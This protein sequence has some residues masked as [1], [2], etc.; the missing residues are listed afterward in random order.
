AMQEVRNQ[1]IAYIFQQSANVFNPSMK[2]GDQ[3]AE[4]ALYGKRTA[5]PIIR[6]KVHALLQSC[7]L[8]PTKRFAEAYPHQLSGGQIQRALIAMAL[9]NDPDLIIADEPTSALDSHLK[10]SVIKLLEKIN[11]LHQTSILIISHDLNLVSKISS[12][13]IVIDDGSVVEAQSKVSL[14]RKPMSEITRDML[15]ASAV[16]DSKSP[17]TAAKVS[18]PITMIEVNALSKSYAAKTSIFKK[19]VKDIKAVDNISFSFNKGEILGIV[20]P[21]GSG[22]ST[23]ARL[24]ALIED[25]DSGT[26]KFEGQHVRELSFSEFEQLKTQVQMIF[27]DPLSALAPHLTVKDVLFEVLPEKNQGL[28]VIEDAL[29]NVDLNLDYLNRIPRMLS[30]GERQRILIARA[31]L[32]QPKLLICDEIL[33]ALDVLTQYRIVQLLLKLNQS[34][35]LSLIFISHDRKLVEFLSDQTIEL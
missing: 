7:G 22:K 19:N 5:E 6:E 34:L 4:S 1:N 10:E 32:T 29:L 16:F 33:S 26:Y 30:G 8:E 23:L 27:Q 20:G 18:N 25:F 2:I 11:E 28:K 3:I 14:M 12:N 9:I 13:I 35:G 31:L 17:N 15:N 21:S 24:L